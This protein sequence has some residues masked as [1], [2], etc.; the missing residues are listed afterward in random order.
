MRLQ[1]EHGQARNN[2]NV[3]YIPHRPQK[4]KEMEYIQIYL[5]DDVD[6]IEWFVD[7]LSESEKIEYEK[8]CGD[9]R[10]DDMTHDEYKNACLAAL[11]EVIN[12]YK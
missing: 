3:G 5:P 10:S 9:I 6:A 12:K 2:G 8:S 11:V 4:E 7:I 1:T